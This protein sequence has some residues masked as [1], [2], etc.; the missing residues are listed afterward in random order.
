MTPNPRTP[1]T[2]H[3][4]LLRRGFSYS[5]GVDGAG[6]LDQGLA[7]ISY[8]RRLSSF[9]AVQKRLEREP[10]EEYIRPAVEQDGDMVDEAEGQLH[11]ML[12][13]HDGEIARKRAHDLGHIGPLG[14]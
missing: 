8:Q 1:E 4:V 3:Q 9:V 5:R 10:L 12:D 2:A 6:Q 14:R 13:E 7:F 11:V